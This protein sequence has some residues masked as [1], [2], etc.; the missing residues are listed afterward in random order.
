MEVQKVGNIS[1]Q[2]FMTRF[3]NPGIPV[4]FTSASKAWKASESVHAGLFSS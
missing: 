1:H 2:E 3:Y 4:I